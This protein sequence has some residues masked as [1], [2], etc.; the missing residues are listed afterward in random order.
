MAAMGWYGP[1]IDLSKASSHIG[2]YVQLLVL[3][4]R[5][6]PIQLII[7]GLLVII[8]MRGKL[9]KAFSRVIER[10]V[11]EAAR[12][13]SEKQWVW[14]ASPGCWISGIKTLDAISYRQTVWEAGSFLEEVDETVSCRKL[15]L[16]QVK[17]AGSKFLFLSA[18]KVVEKATGMLLVRPL[19]FGRSH[20][21]IPQTGQWCFTCGDPDHLSNDCPKRRD[22]RTNIQREVE[23]GASMMEFRMNAIAKTR[24]K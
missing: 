20:K 15:L 13:L 6:T 14:Y 22:G 2:D 17:E 19:R 24:R 8:L 10:G 23:V 7:L 5:S 18:N 21:Q 4:H 11:E 16:A 12:I 3:V 1:L 9:G